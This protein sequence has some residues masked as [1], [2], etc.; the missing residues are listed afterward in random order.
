MSARSQAT[1]AVTAGE[2]AKA[3]ATLGP[4]STARVPSRAAALS[5][6]GSRRR[7]PTQTDSAP[8]SS[9]ARASSRA[10]AKV[11]APGSIIPGRPAATGRPYPVGGGDM[12]DAAQAELTSLPASE[13]AGLIASRRL[14]ATEAVKA[15]IERIE[16]LNGRL[17]AVVVP[18]F[19][20]ALAAAA[21]ADR[22]SAEGRP[23]HGVPVTVKE[24]FHVVGTPSTV[25]LEA[26]RATTP[27][28][29][30][31]LV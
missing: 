11:I 7:S 13:L 4:T 22:A 14:S 26:R 31:D 27:E 6:Y 25:G 30:A 18:M 8:A 1:A 15:H 5:R 2:R 24:C 21:D 3:T 23:L 29:D 20:Q 19:E 28:V 12:T 16:A 9:A 10:S 17:N